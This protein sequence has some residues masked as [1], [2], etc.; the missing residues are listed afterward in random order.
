M[1]PKGYHNELHVLGS[2]I[3]IMKTGG[4]V[5]LEPSFVAIS[6][7]HKDFTLEVQYK[8]THLMELFMKISFTQYI[9]LLPLRRDATSTGCDNIFFVN[10]LLILCETPA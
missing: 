1:Y 5:K 6:T 7:F 10:L 8:R 4:N 3:Q 9:A 2:V